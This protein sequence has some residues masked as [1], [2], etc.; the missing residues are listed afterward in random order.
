M[1]AIDAGTLVRIARVAHEVNRA[2]CAAT[3][4]DSQPSWDDAPQWQI[5]SCILGVL[6]A[7]DGATPEQSHEGWLAKKIADG[8]TYDV[9]KDVDAKKHP[10]VLPYRDLPQ[11]QRVKD[12]LFVAV[13]RS[14][15]AE[16][17]SRG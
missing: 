15:L 10:C 11:F 3:G 7:A 4:D 1:S 8:W 12:H 9:I 17:R 14:M 6:S 13:V 5:E 16:E 2:Y